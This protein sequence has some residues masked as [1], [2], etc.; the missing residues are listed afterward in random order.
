M[1]VCDSVGTGASS[2]GS[3]WPVAVK[4]GHWL[5]TSLR[6]QHS[7]AK[8]HRQQP[9]KHLQNRKGAAQPQ[10]PGEPGQGIKVQGLV[11]VAIADK[12]RNA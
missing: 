9:H 1:S 3:V 2:G 6:H 10:H 8:P 12:H 11:E 4:P 5:A 7:V